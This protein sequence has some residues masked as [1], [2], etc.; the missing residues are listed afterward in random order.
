MV[1]GKI[2]T[3]LVEFREEGIGIFGFCVLAFFRPVFGFWTSKLPFFGF[4]VCCRFAVF[5]FLNIWFSVFGQNTRRFSDLVSVLV[6]GCSYL[7]AGFS[8]A[9]MHLKRVRFTISLNFPKVLYCDSKKDFRQFSQFKLSRRIA[10]FTRIASK[11]TLMKL[12]YIGPYAPRVTNV[13]DRWGVWKLRWFW[14]FIRFFGF[15]RNIFRLFCI[16]SVF[17]FWVIF[18]ETS[19]F[20][21]RTKQARSIRLLL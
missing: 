10:G 13:S 20:S 2:L 4:G 6:F 15:D 9:I 14:F 12:I 8:S 17:R 11:N 21:M 7:V 16:L 3:I 5:P 18:C 19:I 1:I